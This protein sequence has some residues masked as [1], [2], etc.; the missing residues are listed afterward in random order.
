[1]KKHIIFII[2]TILAIFNILWIILG[3]WGNPSL[4]LINIHH[5]IIYWVIL[6]YTLFYFT[7]FLV[8]IFKYLYKIKLDKSVSIII[9]AF[10]SNTI[11]L[12]EVLINGWDGLI[13]IKYKHI[14]F[15]IIFGLFICW[16]IFI[17]MK[18]GIRI[19][20]FKLG[21]YIAIYLLF[22]L[23]FTNT[24]YALFNAFR[25]YLMHIIVFNLNFTLFLENDYLFYGII[26]LIKVLFI[27]LFN[28]II[29]KI[30]KQKINIVMILGTILIIP[31][32]TIMVSYLIPHF[33]TVPLY[34]DPIHWLKTG[35]II[36]GFII[37]ECSY[38]A[39]L[40]DKKEKM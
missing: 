27:L 2:L 34:L 37:Y 21:V 5:S 39:Y 16:L 7:Y 26:I 17:N 8:Y 40:Y 25:S 36:F 1:M 6:L 3:S 13:W 12:I 31:F 4:I 19:I 14:A 10:L 18:N 38:I 32:T 28:I 20:L 30:E 11:W 33:T 9:L 15:Y 24:F 23:I 29:A 22:M 35:S